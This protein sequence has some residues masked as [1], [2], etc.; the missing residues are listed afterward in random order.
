[1]S[2]IINIAKNIV[3]FF[4]FYEPE[5]GCK[6]FNV[7]LVGNWGWL[8]LA[9]FLIIHKKFNSFPIS[10]Q[11]NWLGQ[12]RRLCRYF[13]HHQSKLLR[14]KMIVWICFI[15]SLLFLLLE[16]KNCVFKYSHT[17]ILLTILEI[18]ITLIC[19]QGINSDDYNII[20]EI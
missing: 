20:N 16:K 11:V 19:D 7:T 2:K 14:L 17:G 3:K 9:E 13:T 18:L 4:N 1:M 5:N 8:A 12:V 15:M 10:K 6:I